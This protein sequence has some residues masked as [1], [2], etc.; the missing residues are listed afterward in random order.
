[1]TAR[2]TR[3][4]PRP[5][6]ADR[7]VV[8]LLAALCALLTLGALGASAWLRTTADAMAEGVYEEAPYGARQLQVFYT[9]VADEEVPPEAAAEVAA[10]LPASFRELLDPPRHVTATIAAVVQGLP[11]QVRYSPS[12]LTVVGFPNTADLV[13]VVEGEAP[14]PGSRVG[15]LPPEAAAAYDGPRR[16]PIV[17]VM[18]P[19]EAAEALD[20]ELG[21][22]FALSSV[23]YLGPAAQAPPLLRLTG[24]YEASAPYP[25]PLDDVETARSPAVSD[26]PELTVVRAVALAADDLTVLGANW[27]AQPEVRFTFDPARS[28]T[29]EEAA[30]LVADA[31]SLEVRSWPPVLQSQSRAS[32]T[33][34]GNLAESFLDQLRV[35][36]AVLAV[37]LAAA[38]A[39]AGGLLLAAATLLAR[40]RQEV[41]DVLRARGAGTGWLA[42]LRGREALLLALPGLIAAATLVATTRATA[43]DLLPAGLAAAGAVL[44][45]TL[46]QLPTWRAVPD[47]LRGPAVDG[48]QIVV[49]VLAVGLLVLL[50]GE[51]GLRAGD[52]LLLLLPGVLGAAAAVA[53][54]R[55][56]L[57]GTALLRGR[58]SSSGGVTGLLGTSSAGASARQVLLPVTATALAGAAALLAVAMV[59]QVQASAREAGHRAVGAEVQVGPGQFDAAAVE[60]V[61]GL[62][63]V[64]AA[65]PIYTATGSVT[66][67]TGPEQVTVLAVEPEAYAAVASDS[68][69][70]QLGGGPDGVRA[71]V[72]ASLDLAPGATFSYA[73][74]QVPLETTGRLEEVPGLTSGEPFVLV[75]AETLR[76]SM[77]RRLLRADRLLVAGDPDPAQVSETV[78][79]LW[80]SAQVVT[81]DAVVEELLDDP[82]ARRVLLLAGVAAVLC[83]VMLG[84]AAALIVVLGRPQR[85]RAAAILHALGADRR[86]RRRVA[87]L[88]MTPGLAGAVLAGALTA[89]VVVVLVTTA[90]DLTVLT[91][92]TT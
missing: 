11:E 43:A 30:P 54:V 76:E 37:V 44:V 83:V 91:G 59:V 82:A 9:D 71:V 23:R 84:F 12:Y 38:A 32:L 28:P 53:V 85:R 62:S 45:L 73:Q 90:L 75:S 19:T 18:L 64:T 80:P 72:S 35:S 52:P 69:T 33:G 55:A 68:G 89:A 49:A 65:A 20:V 70:A 58:W 74:A 60:A 5:T 16:S 50:W 86:Q 87:A 78:R 88:A 77:D 15:T 31:R 39:A 51:S 21:S 22:Y 42:L 1:M 92:G 6:T 57:A 25:S 66:T 2:L 48:L 40:R 41:T 17:E 27:N 14:R 13:D 36:S 34:I 47:R 61:A 29:A 81:R 63:G 67:T 24:L 3:L 26:L 10:S 8:V 46:A 7:G 56:T 4:L 79:E